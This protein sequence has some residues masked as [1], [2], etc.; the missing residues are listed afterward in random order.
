MN[1]HR[2]ILDLERCMKE[3]YGISGRVFGDSYAGL[4]AVKNFL[5]KDN[6]PLIEGGLPIAMNVLYWDFRDRP[7]FERE[8]P[9]EAHLRDRAFPADLLLMALQGLRNARTEYIKGVLDS[10]EVFV[11]T[12]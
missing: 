8:F 2:R 1:E 3:G 4:Y 10:E 12:K 5:T 6:I 9:L 11:E 7:P